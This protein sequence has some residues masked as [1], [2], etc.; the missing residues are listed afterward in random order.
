MPLVK[1]IAKPATKAQH[2]TQN[3]HVKIINLYKIMKKLLF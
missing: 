1:R 3:K 2:L